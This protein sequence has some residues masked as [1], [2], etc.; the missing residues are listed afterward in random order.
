MAS[1]TIDAMTRSDS[2]PGQK[3][4]YPQPLMQP[5]PLPLIVP[6][7]INIDAECGTKSAAIKLAVQLL[8]Q[9]GRIERSHELEQ[10]L[11]RREAIASTGFGNGFAIP[12]SRSN[13]VST[14]SLVVLKLREAVDWQAIDNEPVNVVILIAVRE[15]DSS[16]GHLTILSQLARSLLDQGFRER[17][18][19]ES[20]PALLCAFFKAS[21]QS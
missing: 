16:H 9:L 4:S 1:L 13:F 11:L 12:H 6:E 19:T 20:D 5:S 10:A 18:A 3:C 8:Q 14:N 17:I 21:F 7:L 2:I 15:A